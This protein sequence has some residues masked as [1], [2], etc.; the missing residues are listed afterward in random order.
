MGLFDKKI[1]D[2]CGGKVG[3]LT[4][5]KLEDGNIC[6]D[7]KR[8]SRR[9]STSGSIP[10]SHR[11]RSSLNTASKTVLSSTASTRPKA[12]EAAAPRSMSICPW[13]SSLSA[14]SVISARKTRI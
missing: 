10:P 11:S 6:A 3:M 12:T 4:F 8:S 2:I 1:C 9:F 13:A 5:S 14:E 7:C